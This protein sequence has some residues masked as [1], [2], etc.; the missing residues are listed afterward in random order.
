TR[1]TQ[2]APDDEAVW[3]ECGA[4]LA[5]AGR[6]EQALPYF[7]RFTDLGRGTDVQWSHIAPLL[8]YL[9]DRESYRRCCQKML[10]LF[11]RSVDPAV[12]S[13]VLGWGPLAGDSGMDPGLL[14]Q[15]ADRCLAG[16]E[17]HG[18]YRWMV[19]A[20]GLA[21]Y[22]AGRMEHAVKWLLKTE[23]LHGEG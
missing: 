13:H 19:R 12:V 20:K 6:W 2:L 14:L 23:A 21:E 9:N 8:L 22:R 3:F 10:D 11:C 18:G 17:N 1:A 4:G 15:Q 5:A 16:N 7:S